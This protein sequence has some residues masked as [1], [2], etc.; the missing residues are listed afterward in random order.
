MAKKR[1]NSRI[2]ID[3]EELEALHYLRDVTHAATVGELNV[4]KHR[5]STCEAINREQVDRLVKQDLQLA[6][7]RARVLELEAQ[8]VALTP[9]RS[10]VDQPLFATSP[11]RRG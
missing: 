8:L 5:L 9:A 3:R 4:V 11:M 2:D 1:D 6:A 7:A 10:T